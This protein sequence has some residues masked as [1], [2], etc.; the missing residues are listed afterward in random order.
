MGTYY[1]Q[2]ICEGIYKFLFKVFLKKIFSLFFHFSH[3][4][5]LLNFFI[6]PPI[7]YTEYEFA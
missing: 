6:L 1:L 4:Q 3:G 7:S 5:S 2:I